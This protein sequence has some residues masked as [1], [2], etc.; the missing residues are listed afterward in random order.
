MAGSVA[1][2]RLLARRPE[3]HRSHRRTYMRDGREGWVYGS[4]GVGENEVDRL[5]R[6]QS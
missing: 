3:E 5:L 2:V 1:R 4:V 6:V